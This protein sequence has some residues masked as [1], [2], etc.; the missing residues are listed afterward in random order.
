MSNIYLSSDTHFGH[1]RE[2]CWGPRGFSNVDEMNEKIIENFNNIVEPD[3]TL[4][5]LGDVV[6]GSL[7]NIDFV[8]KINCQNILIIR[9]NHD[10][11]N[12]TINYACCPNVLQVYEG[13]IHMKYSKY[14]FFLSHYPALCGNFDDGDNLHKHVINLC[15][16]IHTKDKWHDYDKGIIYHVELD[17]HD[18]KPVLIDDII[19]D[20]KEKY[21][22]KIQTNVD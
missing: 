13:G 2:F 18:N 8:K 15:G 17:A 16:H 21:Y 19:K 5:L 4:Y 20:L 3:D 12:K 10:T 9:G 6:M 14:R 1:D 11:D 22:G 7:D